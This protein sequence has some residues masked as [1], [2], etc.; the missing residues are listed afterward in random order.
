[1]NLE[2]NLILFALLGKIR[3]EKINMAV[4]PVEN[5]NQNPLLFQSKDKYGNSKDI[6][7]HEYMKR[8]LRNE[9]LVSDTVQMLKNEFD[10]FKQRS[11]ENYDDL[12]KK[13]T[14]LSVKINSN[15]QGGGPDTKNNEN[16]FDTIKRV[17]T[18]EKQKLNDL[19]LRFQL[20]ENSTTDGHLI[21]KINDFENRTND[22]IIGKVRAL[23]SAP[24]FTGKYG[25][26]FCLR[27]Y[28]HGD[29]TV[30]YTHL[31]LPTN[32]EV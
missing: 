5:T 31:T 12:I 3:T 23:H 27:L 25:Y 20:H 2:I 28:L 22:A 24:C 29:G 18:D 32:R 15:K 1:M 26:K 10:I 17:L 14:Q 11:E 6:N 21:W 7:Q 16:I 8:T 4:Q 19:D 13:I 9:L 30:S